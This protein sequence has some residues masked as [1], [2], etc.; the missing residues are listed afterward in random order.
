MMRPRR[1]Q[2]GHQHPLRHPHCRPA[3]RN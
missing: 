2:P 1:I 3:L